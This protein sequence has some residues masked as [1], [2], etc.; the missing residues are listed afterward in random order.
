[1]CQVQYT[2]LEV[3]SNFSKL[4]YASSELRDANQQQGETS[5]K[6]PMQ[7]GQ[8]RVSRLL[9]PSVKYS[10]VILKGW[11]QK[12]C[13]GVNIAKAVMDISEKNHLAP[14]RTSF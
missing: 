10:T 12:H 4:E 5:S 9:P 11:C 3:N 1:M 7:L 13:E 14:I 8:L 6:F 2:L